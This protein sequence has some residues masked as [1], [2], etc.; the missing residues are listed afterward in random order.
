MKFDDISPEIKEKALA[1]KSGEELSALAAEVGVELS[2][3]ELEGVSGG[4]WATECPKEG[5]SDYRIS[6]PCS[7]DER[8]PCYHD[9]ML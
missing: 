7:K 4:N 5:C 1:C 9:G 8:K 6:E 3:E 2:D